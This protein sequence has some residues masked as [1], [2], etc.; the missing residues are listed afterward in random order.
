MRAEVTPFPETGE[1]IYLQQIFK[2]IR[3]QQNNIF[4]RS[5]ITELWNYAEH[6]NI[7]ELKMNR[8]LNK[9]GALVQ[10]ICYGFVSIIIIL[11][12]QVLMIPLTIIEG[13]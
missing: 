7:M 2:E 10:I 12:Y 11:A 3:C 13:I 1:N 9:I 8:S 4:L 5:G 6:N